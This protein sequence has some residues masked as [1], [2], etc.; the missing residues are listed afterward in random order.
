MADI[1]EST[2][3]GCCF[4]FQTDCVTTTLVPNPN[5]RP[6]DD[7]GDCAN[8]LT[9]E[10]ET[11]AMMG[12]VKFGEDPGTVIPCPDGVGAIGISM[13]SAVGPQTKI[14]IKRTGH[15]CWSDLACAIGADP[16]DAAA[17]WPIHMALAEANIYVE[18]A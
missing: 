8:Y 2:C 13:C 1:M 9:V 11:Y 6:L 15:L 18:F 16:C 7:C 14:T 5:I 3:G 12:P 10:G 17:W 4:G